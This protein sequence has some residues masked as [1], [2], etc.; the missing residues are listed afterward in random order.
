MR[1]TPATS[2]PAWARELPDHTPDGDPI[3]YGPKPLG[4]RIA[5][6]IPQDGHGLL[7]TFDNGE[8]RRFD[9]RP[10]LSRDVFRS[11]REPEAF[12]SLE[13]VNEGGGVAWAS[14]PDLS[15]ETLYHK[16]AIQ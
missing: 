16:R 5:D 6:I 2:K 12:A 1:P 4:P 9:L 8:M 3:I 11:L 10:L 15:A 13:V 14:G 7:V